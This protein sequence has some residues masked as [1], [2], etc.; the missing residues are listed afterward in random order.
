M[1]TLIY[2]ASGSIKPEYESLPFD[3]IYLVDL[4]CFRNKS[5]NINGNNGNNEINPLKVGKITCIN[6]E[7]IKAIDYLKSKKVKASCYVAINDGCYVTINDGSYTH[8]KRC[9]MNTSFFIGY[10]MSIL[11]DNYVHITNLK[12][13]YGTTDKDAIGV[14]YDIKRLNKNDNKYFDPKIFSKDTNEDI[15]IFQMK[16]IYDV[17]DL[18]LNSDIKISVVRDSIWNYY[19]NLDLIVH[20]ISDFERRNFFNQMPKVITWN[21]I[22]EAKRSYCLYSLSENVWKSKFEVGKNLDIIFSYCI[23]N[24][25]N[26]VGFMPWGSGNYNAFVEKIQN[27]KEKYPKEITLYHLNKDSYKELKTNYAKKKS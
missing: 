18:D 25:I 11:D 24:K 7:C 14:P 1:S 23:Q 17:S 16:K 22:I 10:A 20:S 19:D 12:K 3:D 27:Y 8:I 6:M 5:Q 21:H 4:C 26:R 13:Y 9:P 2:F 15:E